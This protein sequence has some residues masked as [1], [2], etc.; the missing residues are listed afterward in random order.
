MSE[1]LKRNIKRGNVLLIVIAMQ[2]MK[3]IVKLGIV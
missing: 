3:L 1:K 2:I